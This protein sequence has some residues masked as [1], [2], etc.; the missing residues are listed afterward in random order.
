LIPAS[1]IQEWS[2]KAPWPNAEYNVKY[3]NLAEGKLRH[4]DH[5]FEW[6]RATFKAWADT[7]ADRFGYAVEYRAVGDS[8]AQVGAPTQMAVFTRAA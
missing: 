6:D 8:D 5:R 4:S 1:Y 7:V 2:H 3:E